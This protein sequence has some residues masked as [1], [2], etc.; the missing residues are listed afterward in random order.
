[1]QAS[2][3]CEWN[4]FGDDALIFAYDKNRVQ[5]PRK[6]IYFDDD[7]ERMK[8][9][10]TLPAEFVQACPKAFYIEKWE[11]WKKKVAQHVRGGMDI[12]EAREAV[13]KE[14]MKTD[15]PIKGVGCAAA[16][17]GVYMVRFNPIMYFCSVSLVPHPCALQL[18]LI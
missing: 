11:L 18:I 5:F 8:A 2:L 15:V 6:P 14:V 17:N 10:K 4:R 13:K 1:M 16:L 7:I 3:V 12:E 9:N